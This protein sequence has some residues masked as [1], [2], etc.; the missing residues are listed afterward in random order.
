MDQR[1][2]LECNLNRL[3][4]GAFTGRG[5]ALVVADLSARDLFAEG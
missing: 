3:G 1:A 4:G 2:I 5:D